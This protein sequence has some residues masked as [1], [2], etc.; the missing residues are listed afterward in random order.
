ME[1]L[2]D[3]KIN[4]FDRF[5]S[6]LRF[7]LSGEIS[8][9]VISFA[10]DLGLKKVWYGFDTES[11]KTDTHKMKNRTATFSIGYKFSL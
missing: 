4:A 11:Y 1:W 5:D 10:Y 9:F 6:G 3:T 8:R 7:G 2:A